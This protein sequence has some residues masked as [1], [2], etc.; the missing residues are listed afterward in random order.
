MAPSRF[1]Y[2]VSGKHINLSLDGQHHAVPETHPANQAV[3]EAIDKYEGGDL[4]LMDLKRAI[5]N[6]VNIKKGLETLSSGKVT[7]KDGVVYYNGSEVHNVVAER[8]LEMM[9]K[10]N[11]FKYLLSFLDKLM[12]NPSAHCVNSLLIWM[13]RNRI[14]ITDDG[15]LLG[16]K[17]LRPDYKDWFSG[18]F[19]NTPGQSHEVPRNSVD[20]DRTTACS[21]GFHIGSLQ[22]AQSFHGGEGRRMVLCKFSPTDVVSVPNEAQQDKI[23]VCKYTVLT[24]HDARTLL[25]EPCYVVSGSD[26]KPVQPG[27]NFFDLSNFIVPGSGRVGEDASPSPAGQFDNPTRERRDDFEEEDDDEDWDEPE[28]DDEEEEEDDW[29]EDDDF[30]DDDEEEEYSQGYVPYGW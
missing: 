26:Y 14:A 28:Y 8:I 6:L 1:G 9:Q 19:D 3:L 2:I 29:P 27:S 21:F 5:E 15:D 16:Y 10:G 25:T 12:L 18:Q 30:E 22:Y 7:V 24:D 4:T 23:R 17:S 11:P 20:D 13:E